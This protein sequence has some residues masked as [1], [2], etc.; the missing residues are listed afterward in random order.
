MSQPL[1]ALREHICQMAAEPRF[2]HHQWFVS[3]HLEI[4]LR[5][6]HELCDRYP[7]ADRDSIEAMVWLHDYGK[8]LTNKQ[9][10]SAEETRI[11][12]EEGRKKMVELGFLPAFIDKT[13]T[14]L[15]VCENYKNRDLSQEDIEVQIMASADGASHLIGPFFALYWYENP[16]KS[17]A[18]L[19]ASNIA[20][21]EKDWQ[22]KIVLPE[23]KQAFQ[24]R[25]TAILEGET[26]NRKKAFIQ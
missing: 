17:V 3:H 5:L 10:S 25:Y 7:E 11:T 1:A 15:A 26:H 2:I 23:V 24:A 12:L 14:H 4:V 9:V 22:Y 19:I 18:E 6:V 16:D 8:I 13:L 20:K 21:T